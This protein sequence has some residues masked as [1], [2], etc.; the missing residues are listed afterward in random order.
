MYFWKA[1]AV[2]PQAR[3]VLF[4][5]EYPLPGSVVALLQQENASLAPKS[6]F[7][8]SGK[9]SIKITLVYA[10]GALQAGP[11]SSSSA[12]KRKLHHGSSTTPSSR[13][14]NIR[15]RSKNV[16]ESSNSTSNER[17][18][19][20]VSQSDAEAASVSPDLQLHGHQG[21]RE[22]MSTVDS[23]HPSS[24]CAVT[25]E[26]E[27]NSESGTEAGDEA[28]E[29]VSSSDSD[30]PRTPGREIAVPASSI[31]PGETPAARRDEV[32]QTWSRIPRTQASNRQSLSA[33]ISTVRR[34]LSPPTATTQKTNTVT[35]TQRRARLHEGVYWDGSGNL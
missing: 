15:T 6:Y 13:A 4:V 32:W 18:S 16:S 11:S 34:C 2:T 14:T 35:L 5:M 31:G 19:G 22:R 21:G 10:K 23:G 9:K 8:S 7:I 33:P 3:L 12:E 28:C 29:S 27:V 24:S 30:K 26:R 17:G 25:N 20:S 1:E